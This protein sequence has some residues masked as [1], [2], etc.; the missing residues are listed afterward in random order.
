M[1]LLITSHHDRVFYAQVSSRKYL[2]CSSRPSVTTLTKAKIPNILIRLET[3]I[4]NLYS[5]LAGQHGEPPQHPRPGGLR[6]DQRGHMRPLLGDSE[7]L[8]TCGVV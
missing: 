3:M 7:P 2:R 4:D 8:D 6:E 1:S 5:L